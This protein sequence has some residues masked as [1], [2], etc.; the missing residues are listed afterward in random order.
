MA[1][2]SI[3]LFSFLFL[4]TSCGP[5]TS[6][7]QISSISGL[8]K[9]DTSDSSEPETTSVVVPP[10]ESIAPEPEPEKEEPKPEPRPEV[11]PE[12][13]V[14]EPV[15]EEA[16]EEEENVVT[17]PPKPTGSCGNVQACIMNDRIN[18]IRIENGLKALNNDDPCLK[19]AQAHAEDMAKNN[20]FSH[21]GLDGSTP[22]ERLERYTVVTRF[23]ENIASGPANINFIS[24]LWMK[25]TTHRENILSVDF[26]SSGIGFANN[27]TQSYWVQCFR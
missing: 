5:G 2:L 16:P 22:D 14:E 11:T 18:E 8:N 27:E 7:F 15:E 6:E 24:E 19:A 20:Y 12:P 25:S 26:T 3:L 1:K 9:S 4:I 10:E 21:T 23:G 13:E 17:L